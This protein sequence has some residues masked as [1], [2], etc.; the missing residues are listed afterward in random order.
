MAKR[1]AQQCF[2]LFFFV[3]TFVYVDGFNLYNR[4][5]K[6][7]PHKWLDLRCLAQNILSPQNQI[8]S[9]K[10][11][12]A[13]VT[14]RQD[15]GEPNRQDVYLRALATIPGL[16]IFYGRFLD[17]KIM[18]PLVTPISGQPRFVQ[19]HS[20]EEKGS[21]VNL[22]CHLLR[23]AHLDLFDVAAVI[24]K[25]TDLAEPIRIVSEE[26]NKPVGVI[27]PDASCPTDLARVAV[28][29]RHITESILSKSHFPTCIPVI[30]G[31]TI[32]KPSTWL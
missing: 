26:L 6:G 17:K 30:G 21:D 14:G 25:D 11:Y 4:A 12:T 5:L 7:T 8:V 15:P 9:I 19:V 23:D 28:F 24:S 32:S 27:V 3:R 29:K 18:R 20:T 1:S 13:R 16:Q 22:A 10:Y 2:G 31:A